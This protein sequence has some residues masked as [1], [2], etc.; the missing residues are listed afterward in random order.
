MWPFTTPHCKLYIVCFVYCAVCTGLIAVILTGSSQPTSLNRS[1]AKTSRAILKPKSF[2]STSLVGTS[3]WYNG[4]KLIKWIS[5]VR[6]GLNW[7]GTQ[8]D[9][10]ELKWINWITNGK[11]E[12]RWAW[13]ISNGLDGSLHFSQPSAVLPCRT[14][15][16][17]T[18]VLL[19][20]HI[21]KW[22]LPLVND[23]G[24]RWCLQLHLSIFIG[25]RC[26][27]GS[28]YGSGCLKLTVS[29][30]QTHISDPRDTWVQ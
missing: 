2:H 8:I 27:W 19:I 17:L 15:S 4:S 5:N 7:D 21:L 18:A 13:W 22:W 16:D 24:W 26:L 28:I 6:N 12:L 29:D 1:G 11:N 10:M 25:P 3:N 30:N 9:R 14:K 23:L 20:F